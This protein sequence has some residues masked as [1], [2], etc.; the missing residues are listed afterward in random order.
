VKGVI[1]PPELS[2]Q[3][4]YVCLNLV[5]KILADSGESPGP[6]L[7]GA[8][9]GMVPDSGFVKKTARSQI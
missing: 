4:F 2:D 8:V 5:Q 9:Q 7:L 6:I 1:F 3:G